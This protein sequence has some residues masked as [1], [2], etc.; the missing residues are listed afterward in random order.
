[1]NR[2]EQDQ[3]LAL[4]EDLL[5]DIEL[6]RSSV[7]KQVLKASRLARLVNDDKVS[8]WLKRER[9]GYFLG[10][11]EDYPYFAGTSRKYK[12]AKNHIYAG[13]INVQ[14]K[15]LA[16]ERE[17]SAMRLPDVAGDRAYTVTSS[18]LQRMSHIRN[19]IMRYS[20]VL[21]SVSGHLHSFATVT[22]HS[23]RFATKQESM[24]EKAKAEIDI[25]LLQLDETTLR[26]IDSAFSNLQSGDE[27][28]ISAAMN[29]VRRLIDGFTDAVFPPTKETRPHPQ[30]GKPPILLGQQQRM[31]RLRAF[32]DDHCPSKS[33]AKR[34]GESAESVYA[35]VSNGVHNDASKTEADYLFLSTYVLLGEILNLREKSEEKVVTVTVDA[36]S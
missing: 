24:F 19:E 20:A 34:L 2:E 32:I 21:A 1:M 33:R 25:L 35:R 5:Q 7:D 15:I 18:A 12:E 23:L 3:A 28:S 27:E 16:Y 6:D 31:N 9:Q 26:K 36:P 4:A 14:A 8:K 29:S 13:A 17:L 22:Y 30:P 11:E 10:D